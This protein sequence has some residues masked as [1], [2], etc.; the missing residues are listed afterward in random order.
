MVI[1]HSFLYVYQRVSQMSHDFS[2]NFNGIY[3]MIQQW[4]KICSITPSLRSN[5]ILWSKSGGSNDPQQK[6]G[7]RFR[8][9][10]I[11]NRD[12]FG[13]SQ[14]A[15]KKQSNQQKMQIRSQPHWHTNPD[16]ESRR[17]K[18]IFPMLIWT[19]QRTDECTKIMP[20]EK[21]TAP[22]RTSSGKLLVIQDF[23]V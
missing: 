22:A 21:Q 8:G 19:I 6:F 10:Q 13:G 20:A 15:K 2:R 9:I 23:E 17:L 12:I 4:L 18:H 14:K 3:L 11:I 1:V 16:N 7:Y 5:R